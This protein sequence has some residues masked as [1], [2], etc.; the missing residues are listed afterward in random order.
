MMKRCGPFSVSS[1]VWRAACLSSSVVATLFSETWN[2]FHQLLKLPLRLPLCTWIYFCIRS[3]MCIRLFLSSLEH[4]FSQWSSFVTSVYFFLFFIHC[5]LASPVTRVSARR[6]CACSSVQ[7]FSPSSCRQADSLSTREERAP[8]R[9][10]VFFS[11]NIHMIR[12]TEFTRNNSDQWTMVSPCALM[13]CVFSLQQHHR[14]FIASP[15]RV[16]ST[17]ILW[18]RDIS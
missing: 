13:A 4:P 2:W 1:W 5:V 7:R 9:S 8:T 10:S 15:T 12:V 11:P 6:K 17:L 14:Y 3:L 18:V 16:A